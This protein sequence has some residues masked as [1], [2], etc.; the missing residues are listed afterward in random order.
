MGDHAGR[1]CTRGRSCKREMLQD[2]LARCVGDACRGV[3]P[4]HAHGCLVDGSHGVGIDD[5]DLA[6]DLHQQ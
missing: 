5:I 3:G 4:L 6:P 2:A 1:S